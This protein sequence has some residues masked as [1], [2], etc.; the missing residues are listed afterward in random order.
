MCAPPPT[1]VS[2][3]GLSTKNKSGIVED[4]VTNAH[5]NAMVQVC[6]AAIKCGLTRILMWNEL[7]P[8]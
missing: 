6:L 8:M 3:A 7:M 2:Y 4:A 1:P 5:V